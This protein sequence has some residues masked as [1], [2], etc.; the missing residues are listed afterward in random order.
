MGH[1]KQSPLRNGKSNFSILKNQVFPFLGKAFQILSIPSQQQRKDI[2]RHT[3][4]NPSKKLFQLI[5]RI[6]EQVFKE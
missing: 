5:I 6:Q 2:K 3:M 1:L 4:I